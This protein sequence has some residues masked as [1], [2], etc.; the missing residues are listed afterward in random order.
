MAAVL[1]AD[2]DEDIRYVIRML[3]EDECYS[4][5]E[6]RNG[7][8]ALS[9][10]NTS[11]EPLITLLD[12]HMPFLTGVNVLNVVAKREG[13]LMRH[14]YIFL[15]PLD[16]HRNAKLFEMLTELAIPVLFKPFESDDLLK[17]VAAAQA[18]IVSH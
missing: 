3:L 1:I 12:E 14:A 11:P 16:F 9:I 17:A 4:V 8:D 10:L 6:A 13:E 5:C 18:R 7:A 2:E 15:T